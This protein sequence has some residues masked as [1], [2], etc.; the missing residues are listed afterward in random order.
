MKTE[1]IKLLLRK[2]DALMAALFVRR[3]IG[4]VT[5]TS[6]LTVLIS[7]SDVPSIGV[8]RCS[9]YSP[10]IGDVVIVDRWGIDLIVVDEI[11]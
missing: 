4:E 1:T 7:G 10:T 2:I 11:V 8:K 5:A 3:C 9:S 6:P